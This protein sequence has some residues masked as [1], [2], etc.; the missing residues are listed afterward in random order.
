MTFQPLS[1]ADATQLVHLCWRRLDGLV[2]A[3]LPLAYRRAEALG[4]AYSEMHPEGDYWL[5]A[6]PRSGGLDAEG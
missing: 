2:F 1:T 6:I 5:H 4:L 3:S